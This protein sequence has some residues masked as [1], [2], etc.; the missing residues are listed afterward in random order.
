MEKLSFDRRQLLKKIG[1]VGAMGLF[2]TLTL[3]SVDSSLET[4]INQ[5]IKSQRN[6][7]IVSGNE[8][9]AWSVYDFTRQK[10]LVSINEATP[11]QAASMVKPFVALAYFYL[12]SKNA[13]KYPYSKTIRN[14]MQQMLVSSSNSSTNYLMK[15]CGGPQS[16]G[17]YAQKAT[18][19]RFKQLKVVEYIPKSGRTYKNK[20]SAHDYSKFLYALWNNQLPKS[21]EMKRIM[22]MPN[23][24]RIASDTTIPSS[25]KIIDKTGSTSMLCGDMGIVVIRK[26]GK[27]YPYTFI[28]IIERSN[29]T[30]N[31]GRWIASR[32]NVMRG[33]SEI[34]YKHMKV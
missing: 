26:N 14:H 11:L 25:A 29:R 9:T 16:V 20:A 13:T 27:N 2:P 4:K 21:A 23:R 7:G 8:R 1:L 10:K 3:A 22:S 32:G 18:G 15:K 28:G 30:K 31:Y 17:K 34:V 24:D 6:K 5:F 19:N 33:V 12:N